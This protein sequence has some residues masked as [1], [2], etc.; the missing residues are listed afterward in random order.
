MPLNRI[1]MVDFAHVLSAAVSDVVMRV[2]PSKI[3]ISVMPV[4]A[5]NRTGFDVFTDDRL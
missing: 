2:I 3:A 1:C 5:N 4:T